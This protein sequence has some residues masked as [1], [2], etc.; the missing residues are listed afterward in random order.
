MDFADR[1]S[2]SLK[3]KSVLMELEDFCW[4]NKDISKEEYEKSFTNFHDEIMDL[5]DKI[6][7]SLRDDEIIKAIKDF[8]KIDD[9]LK[10]L[11]N[12][13]FNKKMINFI[14]H[15]NHHYGQYENVSYR[16]ILSLHF[17]DIPGKLFNEIF[18]FKDY[19]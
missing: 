1:F 14:A 8:K 15:I 5:I 9:N 4:K 10:D 11:N 12:G 19:I 17:S 18:K 2:A 3:V 16:E 6:Y 13:K 7:R